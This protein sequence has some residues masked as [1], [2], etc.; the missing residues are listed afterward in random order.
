MLCFHLPLKIFFMFLIKH[1]VSSAI[2]LGHR[3]SFWNPRSSYFLLGSKD[4]LHIIDLEQSVVYFR[5]AI[6][7]IRRICLL[8]GSIFYIPSPLSSGPI[9]P[10]NSHIFPCLKQSRDILSSLTSFHNPFLIFPEALFI[11]HI[12]SDLLLIKESIKLQIPLIAI[13]DSNCN[14]YGIQYPIPG[15]STAVDS[16]NFYIE[17]LTNSLVDSK[18]SE[19]SLLV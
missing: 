1:F 6:D 14:P 8:R 17:L 2:H 5:R 19:F 10:L 3:T 18:K 12:D 9:I 11:L 16:I 15:N 13:L 7:F 4:G